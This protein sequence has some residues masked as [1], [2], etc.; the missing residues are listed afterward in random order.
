MEDKGQ[1]RQRP[2][3][4]IQ[5]DWPSKHPLST[6]RLERGTSSWTDKKKPETMHSLTGLVARS[7]DQGS[8]RGKVEN[9][10]QRQSGSIW[11]TG[12]LATRSGWYHRRLLG[13][14]VPSYALVFVQHFIAD[15][16]PKLRY[17]CSPIHVGGLSGC[18]SSDGLR[19]RARALV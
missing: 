17:P 12:R 8:T 5:R 3:Q 7:M 2:A 14:K 10:Q 13:N 4:A 6:I 19:R 16:V 1:A 18:R 11:M 15:T 9:L